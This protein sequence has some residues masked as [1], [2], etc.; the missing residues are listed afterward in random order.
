MKIA[1]IATSQIPSTKA[2]SIQVMKVCQALVMNGEAVELFV[3]GK[4]GTDWDKL[5]EQYGISTRFPITWLPSLPILK[6]V[7]FAINCLRHA[8]AAQA[9]VVYTRML[10]AAWAA[11]F[12]GLPVI[13]EMHDL[14][15]GRMGPKLYRG[16]MRSNSKKLTVY[17]TQALKLLADQ[18]SGIQPKPGRYAIAPDGV[19]LF[20]Y[21]NLPQPEAARMS[22]HL[23]EKIT[24]A[25]SG[26][27]YPGR[28]LETLM[29][30]AMAFP[31]I[32]FLWIG[33]GEDQVSKWKE[34]LRT[35]GIGNVHLTGF[36][37]N[38]KLPL[39]QAA[40]DILLM[41]YGK[42]FS[43][44][45]G[46]NI[47]SVS[48]PMK[49]FEY[50]ASGRIILA[51]DLPVLR[52]VL[53]ENN[54]VFAPAGDLQALRNRFSEIIDDLPSYRRLGEKAE[55]DVRQYEW[56]TRMKQILDFFVE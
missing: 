1:Y 24:A 4:K 53:D 32:N 10:W 27:F 8:R 16:Y 46:G 15:A 7:D 26:G 52:E 2:N 34:E 36:I 48:S 40:A 47:A 38:E 49:M 39:Y 37:A 51:S 30:L 50:M 55:K 23:P 54:A 25:Y 19:D 56:R 6:R 17:I 29:D 31:E 12:F 43:G 42:Q 13:L 33:G 20:R 9:D 45:G 11:H 35:H 28:G 21:T 22:L 14:P 3:P 44:S 41:P 18:A 5:S